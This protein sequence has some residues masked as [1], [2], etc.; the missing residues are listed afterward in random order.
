MFKYF[1]KLLGFTG[2][3]KFGGGFYLFRKN[4]IWQFKKKIGDAYKDWLVKQSRHPDNL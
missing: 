3:A 4:S 1:L 2:F